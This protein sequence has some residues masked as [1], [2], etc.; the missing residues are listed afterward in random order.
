MLTQQISSDLLVW[1][2][3][4]KRRFKIIWKLVGSSGS[5]FVN[6]HLHWNGDNTCKRFLFVEL[7]CLMDVIFNN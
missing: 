5:T 3:D 6:D 2:R 7:V 4:S 1:Q